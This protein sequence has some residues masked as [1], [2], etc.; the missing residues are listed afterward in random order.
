[1]NKIRKYGKIIIFDTLA[2][3]CFVGV[4]L[5]GWIPGPGG[6]P[7]FIL[8]LS[9]LAVNHDW[10]ERWLETAKHK[11]VT[12]KKWLFPDIQW[13]RYS[14]DLLSITTFAA[15]T[16]ALFNSETRFIEGAAVAVMIF[17][18]FI[19]LINRDRFDKIAD[20]FKR[21]PKP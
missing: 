18:L 2:I 21:K 14:Y 13:I 1:M 19:F 16:Y 17:S 12:F 15:G 3:L 5:F 7:L 9:L 4:I 11:G 6:I 8:G 20:T 10:A